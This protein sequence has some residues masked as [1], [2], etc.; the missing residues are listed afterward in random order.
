MNFCIGGASHRA[1]TPPTVKTSG[2]S[3]QNDI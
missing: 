1:G 2:E 3:G